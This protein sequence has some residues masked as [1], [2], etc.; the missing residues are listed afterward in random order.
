MEQ[1]S[2]DAVADMAQSADA[3]DEADVQSEEEAMPLAGAAEA[4]KEDERVSIVQQI[5]ACL[6]VLAQHPEQ[7]HALRHLQPLGGGVRAP[8]RHGRDGAHRHAVLPP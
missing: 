5:E 8:H 1:R 7:L 3:A 4:F 6:A 2:P